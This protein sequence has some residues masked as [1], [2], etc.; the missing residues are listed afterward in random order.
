MAGVEAAGPQAVGVAGCCVVELGG[1][2][3]SQGGQATDIVRLRLAPCQRRAKKKKVVQWAADV[4][5]NE[6]LGRKS[7]KKC[8]I[9]H[10]RREFGD[11]SDSD[12]DDDDSSQG[13]GCDC[14]HK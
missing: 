7:S 13:A 2:A 9:F 4:V 10:K 14:H 3:G 5:D 1:R 11:W 12:T 8:C 6:F